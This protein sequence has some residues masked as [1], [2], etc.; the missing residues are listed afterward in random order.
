MDQFNRIFLDFARDLRR[1]K[2]DSCES[3]DWDDGSAM[4]GASNEHGVVDHIP[5]SQWGGAGP[6]L[7]DRD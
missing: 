7:D 2:A 4:G 1:K 5:D 3:A 6:W